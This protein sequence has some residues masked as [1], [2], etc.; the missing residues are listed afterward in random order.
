M[1]RVLETPLWPMMLWYLVGGDYFDTMVVTI[2]LSISPQLLHQ[3]NAGV[4]TIIILEFISNEIFGVSDEDDGLQLI[5][6]AAFIVIALLCII[7]GLLIIILY[8]RRNK[9]KSENVKAAEMI[10]VKTNGNHGKSA[11]SKDIQRVASHT[12][13]EQAADEESDEELYA[14]GMEKSM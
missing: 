11:A 14:L 12:E 4:L 7:I 2:P 13:N 1:F 9:A 5:V 8:K 6:I 10:I 3:L